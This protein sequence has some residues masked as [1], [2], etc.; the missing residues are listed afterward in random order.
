MGG[1]GGG[2]EKIKTSEKVMEGDGG[3]G[4]GIETSGG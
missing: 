2:W 4:E 3:G 1:D